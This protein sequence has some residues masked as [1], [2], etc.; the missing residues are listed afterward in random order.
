MRADLLAGIAVA[1]L[2]I[3]QSLAYAELAGMPPHYGLYAALIPAIVG[4]LWGSSHLLSTGPVA[5]TS[6]LTAASVSQLTSPGS[7]S[8][9]AHVMLLALLSG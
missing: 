4:V 3:P 1:L 9:I 7:E 8:F 2:V 5:L 6:L